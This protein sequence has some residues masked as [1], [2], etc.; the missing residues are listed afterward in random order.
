MADEA[1]PTAAEWEELLPLFRELAGNGSRS[2]RQ[3]AREIGLSH[4]SLSNLLSETPPTPYPKNRQ[5]IALWL[6]RETQRERTDLTHDQR[7]VLNRMPS[8]TGDALAEREDEAAI[9]ESIIAD[10]NTL[11]RA[12]GVIEPSHVKTRIAIIRE[13]ED[14]YIEAGYG[15]SR[16]P[17]WFNE[18]R[19]QVYEAAGEQTDQG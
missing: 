15:P 10:P 13:F 12:L 19:R 11:R 14:M 9:A 3:I 18:L 8:V 5:R 4:A 1:M 6:V 2:I 16:W 17:A 7:A